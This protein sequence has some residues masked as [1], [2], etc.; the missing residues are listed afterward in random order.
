MTEDYQR[1]VVIEYR[2][3]TDPPGTPAHYI[4]QAQ[5]AKNE[6]LTWPKVQLQFQWR[7]LGDYLKCY[8]EI[9]DNKN[10]YIQ[11][12]TKGVNP[13]IPAACLREGEGGAISLRILT[14]RRELFH[15][16]SS[17]FLFGFSNALF[18]AS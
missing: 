9:L 5:F 10:R 4:D 15:D 11:A 13:R 12:N 2:L 16:T 14:R 6:E 3:D 18:F 7:G 1:I 17:K 8:W